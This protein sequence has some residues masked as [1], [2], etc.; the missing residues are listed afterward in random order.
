M[1]W[2]YSIRCY[3][4]YKQK[5]SFTVLGILRIVE[6]HADPNLRSKIDNQKESQRAL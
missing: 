5:K 2:C 6:V 3:S 1:I 4:D